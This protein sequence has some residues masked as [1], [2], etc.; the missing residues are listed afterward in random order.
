LSTAAA[1]EEVKG[2]QAYMRE[3]WIFGS[4][5]SMERFWNL[6]KFMS[7]LLLLQKVIC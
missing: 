4:W 1:A 2:S 3:N 5:N 6:W 7:W